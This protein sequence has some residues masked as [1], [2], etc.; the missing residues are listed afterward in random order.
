M[1]VSH[2][3]HEPEYATCYAV[4]QLERDGLPSSLDTLEGN[5]IHHRK[6]CEMLLVKVR[7][8]PIHVLIAFVSIFPSY[9][10]DASDMDPATDHITSEPIASPHAAHVRPERTADVFTLADHIETA[11]AKL[12]DITGSDDILVSN[13]WAS[14][15]DTFGDPSTFASRM[16]NQLRRATRK[17]NLLKRPAWLSRVLQ[18]AVYTLLACVVYFFLVGWPLW[19]GAIYNFWYVSWL[20]FHRASH[21]TR[22][23]YRF[24][25]QKYFTLKAGTAIFIGVAFL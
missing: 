10:L 22:F 5:C 16:Q 12:S 25:Y 15:R 18:Y 24:A 1:L 2:G 11:S 8:I 21:L 3:L 7:Y 6:A 23:L 9:P 20:P 19:H 14:S 13:S 17:N 4:R